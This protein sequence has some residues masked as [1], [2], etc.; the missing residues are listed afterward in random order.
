MKRLFLLFLFYSFLFQLSAQ[1]SSSDFKSKGNAYAKIFY[2]FHYA[3]SD[4]SETAFE[5]TRAYL[6]YQHQISEHFDA[7]VKLDIGSPEDLSEYSKIRRYAYFKNAYLRYKKEKFSLYLGLIDLYQFKIQEKYWGHRYIEKSFM[8]AYRFG[9]SADIGLRAMYTANDIIEL[10]F[11]MING[12]GY[13]N[14]QSDNSY[15][16]ALG[17]SIYPVKNLIC[18]VYYDL[19]VKDVTESGLASFIG[20]KMAEKFVAG[21]EYNLR[22][23]SGFVENQM[24]YGYSVYASYQFTP[25]WQLFSRYD[26]LRSNI[27]SAE[28]RP[29]SLSSDGSALIAGIEY[30]PKKNVKF[31]LNYQ[32]WVPYAQNVGADQF[33]YVNCEFNL[34]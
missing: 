20:Y 7:N 28:D 11:S 5:I 6:G 27:L 23:N 13:N 14:L 1:N 30:S 17:L 16:Y 33:I 25:Q 3:L 29:W 12:E 26:Y 21:L 10:D 15:K 32:D 8:D 9:S 19:E 2:N 31:A 24:K 18:R 22:I 34:K 4:E